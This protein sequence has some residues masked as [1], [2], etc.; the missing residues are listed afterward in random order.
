[1]RDSAAATHVIGVGVAMVNI[2]KFT[3]YIQFSGAHCFARR[4]QASGCYW[5]TF[6]NAS[7]GS[8]PVVVT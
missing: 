2:Y 4:P 8:P 6:H 7:G 3:A 5:M 1:M